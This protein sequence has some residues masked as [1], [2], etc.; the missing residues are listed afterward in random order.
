MLDRLATLLG[1]CLTL[2]LTPVAAQDADP[3]MRHPAV[4]PNGDRIAFSY[5][6]DLWTI[7]VDGGTPERLTIH[8]AYD[9]QPR[10]APSGNRIA[11][12]SDRFGNDDL[13]VMDAAGSTPTRLTYHS[14]G[15]AIGGWT[16]D[17]RVL[18]ATNRTYAQAEWSDEIYEVNGDGGTP[19]RLLDAMGASP[20]H[21]A[22]RALRCV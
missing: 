14:T 17:G 20:R 3:F 5:Q 4:H 21:V 15:D 7:P 13:Y 19:D 18:F 11:F 2:G 22:R 16:P 1:L 6:G 8:E 10:W 12:T 9:G